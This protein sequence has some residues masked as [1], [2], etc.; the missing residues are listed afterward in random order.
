MIRYP[1]RLIEVDLPSG[2]ISERRLMLHSFDNP[3]TDAAI[4]DSREQSMVITTIPPH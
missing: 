3:I 4:K 2:R 1:K